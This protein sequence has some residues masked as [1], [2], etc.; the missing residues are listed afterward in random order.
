MAKEIER[1]YLVINESYKEMAVKSVRI[2][3]GYISRR[4]EATVRVRIKGDSAFLTVKGVTEGILR[5]EWEYEIPVDDATEMLR[6][7]CEGK[8]IDKVR[9]IVPFEGFT[10]EV[11]QF[12]GQLSPLTIAEVELPS[13]D[14]N[15]VLP[16]FVGEDVSGNPAYYNS[17]L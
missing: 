4:K 3:Q 10:W 13:A 2:I 16:D 1:K 5:N 14:T 7:A 6:T 15:P 11:D 8:V 12:N 17:N 9:Y